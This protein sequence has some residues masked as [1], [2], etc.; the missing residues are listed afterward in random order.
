MA[1]PLPA[2]DRQSGLVGFHHSFSSFPPARH[3]LPSAPASSV[4][5]GSL[6]TLL[7]VCGSAL[8]YFTPILSAN[9][10]L[11]RPFFLAHQQSTPTSHASLMPERP[12]RVAF[13]NSVLTYSILCESYLLRTFSI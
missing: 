3:V 1:H 8:S 7:L 9:P 10:F 13:T 6:Y 5:S 12:D 4:V 2:S 11:E